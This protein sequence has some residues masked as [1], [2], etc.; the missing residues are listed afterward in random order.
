MVFDADKPCFIATGSPFTVLTQGRAFEVAQCN[1]LYAFPGIAAG[2]IACRARCLTQAMIIAAA[3]QISAY[4]LQ[5]YQD[6]QQITPKLAD[7]PHVAQVVARGVLASAVA[8]DHA[9]FSEDEALQRLAN[10]AWQ[11]HYLPYAQL[12][13]TSTSC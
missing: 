13:Q 1:N 8:S 10:H 5:H 9:Y 2:M 4:T 6:A 7:L 11:P 3:E 12:D